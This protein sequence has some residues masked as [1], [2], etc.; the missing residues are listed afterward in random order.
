MLDFGPLGTRSIGDSEYER[1]SGTYL[2]M[3]RET[4][5]GH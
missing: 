2:A 1:L 4:R 5:Q 3:A